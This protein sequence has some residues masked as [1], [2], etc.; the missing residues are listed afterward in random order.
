MRV[1]DIVCKFTV[2]KYYTHAHIRLTVLWLLLCNVD[3]HL[4]SKLHVIGLCTHGACV[5]VY[6][7]TR[8]CPFEARR[9]ICL[10]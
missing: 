7:C 1:A 6:L 10:K 2:S 9:L 3:M 4:L 5:R 8:N